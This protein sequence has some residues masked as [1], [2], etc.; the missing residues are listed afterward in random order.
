MEVRGRRSRPRAS[1][2]GSITAADGEI[3]AMRRKLFRPMNP[4]VI[5]D[6]AALTLAIVQSE[7]ADLRPFG[8]ILLGCVDHDRRPTPTSRSGWSAEASRHCGSTGGSSLQPSPSRGVFFHKTL[9]WIARQLLILLF[10][11]TAA[12][13]HQ[14]KFAVRPRP[15]SVLCHGA[16]RHSHPMAD[17][18]IL[19]A[20]TRLYFCAMNL[21]ALLGRT[22]ICPVTTWRKAQR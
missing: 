22:H 14:P 13:I 6:D 16:R 3:F 2:L 21:A 10:V 20:R 7:D 1:D 17:C 8:K 19:R 12:P 18:T 4:S 5:N 15:V 11:G 9:R